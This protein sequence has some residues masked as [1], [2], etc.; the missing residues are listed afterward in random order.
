MNNHPF[1]DN[2]KLDDA[3]VANATRRAPD[4]NCKQNTKDLQK[5]AP[6]PAKNGNKCGIAVYVL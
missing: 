4:A 3:K 2:R 1:Q 5:S 6:K